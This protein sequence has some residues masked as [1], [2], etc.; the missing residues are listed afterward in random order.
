MF[1]FA[2][3]FAGVLL[4]LGFWH[5][6]KDRRAILVCIAGSLL[7]DVIDKSL[8]LLF[9]AVFAG[10][11]TVF[12]SLGLVFLLLLITLMFIQSGHRLL[13]VG[14]AGA[15]LLH[16][17]FDEMWHEPANWFYPLLGPF[18]GSMIPDFIGTY[19]WFEITNPSEW[20]FMVG[21][22]AVLI[23]SYQWGA[24]IPVPFLSDRM[25]S[26]AYTFIVVVFGAVGFYLVAAG[27]MRPAGT[28]I[29]PLYNQMTNVM[30]G[31]LAL[32]GA[33]IMSVEKYDAPYRIKP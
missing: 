6:A 33:G 32:S 8:G 2:H 1:I 10:G 18:Q 23:K 17:V 27:L 30:A 20:M 13:G 5:L 7:P 15:I 22:V 25:K 12:H 9:P 28:F 11:R 24:R 21:T 3:A 14:I 31:L 26:A 19:F 16:Q 29:T 4:G